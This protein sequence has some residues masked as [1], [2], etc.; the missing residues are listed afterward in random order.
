[1]FREKFGTPRQP[2]LVPSATGCLT[3]HPHI[4]LDSLD[5]LPAYSHVWLLWVFHLDQAQPRAHL[6]S[7]V[8]PPRL[9]GTKCGL[10]ATRSPHRP[11]PVGLSVG[12][13]ERVEGRR[14]WV[15]GMDLVD[16]TPVI[17]LKPYHPADRVAGATWPAW[18][19][20]GMGGTEEEPEQRMEVR[21]TEGVERDMR[22]WAAQGRLEWFSDGDR[23][24]R[25]VRQCIAQDPR[26][27]NAKRKH[28]GRYG[29][30]RR[31]DGGEEEEEGEGEE[32]QEGEE[33]VDTDEQAADG[34]TDEVDD[35]GRGSGEVIYGVSLDRMDV[36]FRILWTR[37][38]TQGLSAGGEELKKEEEASSDVE[39]AEV[40]HVELTEKGQ[41]R[42]KLRRRDWYARMRCI[43]AEQQS[44][45]S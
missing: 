7:K 8:R 21:M 14:V 43:R 33:A 45:A 6:N 36:A 19:G 2:S 41:V 23:A 10:F 37:R 16:G 38:R 20:E 24:V 30:K 29:V 1:M 34:E 35:G 42:T 22:R 18:V 26:T 5:S 44:H 15:S 27:L 13:L 31:E 25:A 12:R 40:F 3:L 4:P 28:K 9:E 39:V 17:D 11:S 32:G